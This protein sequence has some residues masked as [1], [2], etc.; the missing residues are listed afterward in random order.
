MQSDEQ[1]QVC[2]EREQETIGTAEEEHE[3]SVLVQ[4]IKAMSRN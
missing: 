4:A 2:D 3:D 1:L